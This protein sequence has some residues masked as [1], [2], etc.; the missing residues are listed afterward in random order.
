MKLVLTAVL[1]PF[2]L[3]RK[4]VMALFGLIQN[5]HIKY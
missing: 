2:N 1:Q 3:T 5:L 4:N